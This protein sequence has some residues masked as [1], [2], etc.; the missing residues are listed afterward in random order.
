MAYYI[1][2][3]DI[4]NA[5]IIAE[6]ALSSIDVQYQQIRYNIWMA[7][8]NLEM[9]Y[10]DNLS[11]ILKQCLLSNSAK[12][13]LLEVAKMYYHAKKY[14]QATTTFE[15]LCKTS[16]SIDIFEAY[17]PFYIKLNQLMRLNVLIY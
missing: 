12:K 2:L 14:T 8:L 9:N 13:V 6:R 11:A 10:G 17:L 7:Y 1:E 15:K 16:P 3:T 4:N 5:R